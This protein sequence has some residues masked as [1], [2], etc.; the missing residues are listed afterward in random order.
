MSDRCQNNMTKYHGNMAELAKAKPKF[1]TLGSRF[2][3][4]IL[5]FFMVNACLYFNHS[6]TLFQVFFSGDSRVFQENM[7]FLFGCYCF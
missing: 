5:S 1:D 4:S 7:L 2:L 3:C 6:D